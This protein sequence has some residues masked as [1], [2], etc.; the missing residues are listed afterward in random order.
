MRYL[1]IL[2]S[3]YFIVPPAPAQQPQDNIISVTASGE[4][5]LPADIIQFNINLNAEA[6]TPQKAYE[7]HKEREKVLVDLLDRYEVNEDQIR[8]QPISI[9]KRYTD[10]YVPGGERERKEIFQTK[11]QVSLALRDFEIY[12]QI[13]VTLI[14]HSFDQFSG[15]FLSSDQQQ[16]EDE[17][18]RQAMRKAQNK[19][20]IIA[21]EAGV[22]LG[23]IKSINYHESQ[24]YP[25]QRME[26]MAM[27]AAD[28]PSLM[29]Y[30]QTVI[31][32]ASV[33]IQYTIGKT[34]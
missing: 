28:S 18:L 12:E 3:F 15:N 26:S 24:Y 25:G 7:L 30:E 14:E 9:Q 23:D 17:A 19:V 13:Q 1:L 20:D 5:E 2:L 21:E 34:N 16:G 27:K 33:T 32:E 29:Q 31:L 6:D 11:Q 10:E 22:V 4:V 8:F